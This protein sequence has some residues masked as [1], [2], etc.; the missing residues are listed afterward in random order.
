MRVARHRGHQDAAALPLGADEARYQGDGVA[1]VL[2]ETRALAKDAAELVEVT[3]EPLPAIADVEK[4]LAD[5][6]PLVHADFES[7]ECYVWKLEADDVQGA[8]T[9]RTSS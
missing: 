2:A 8:S 6:A 7:N 1:V 9:R 5:D 3:Y 4:A